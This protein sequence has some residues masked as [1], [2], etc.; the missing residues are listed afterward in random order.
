[1]DVGTSENCFEPLF[2]VEFKDDKGNSLSKVKTDIIVDR[3]ELKELAALRVGETSTI[4]FDAPAEACQMKIS[5]TFKAQAVIFINLSGTIGTMPIS[6]SLKIAPDGKVLGAYY[7][8]KYEQQYFNGQLSFLYL[9]G[10]QNGNHITMKEYTKDGRR[11]GSYSGELHED[12]TFTGTFT[13]NSGEHQFSLTT[14]SKARSIDFS[15]VDIDALAS[16]IV[17]DYDGCSSYETDSED[18]DKILDYYE[19]YVDKCISLAKRTQNGDIEALA[20][21]SSL[22]EEAQRLSDRL[23][24]AKDVMSSSQW[25][26]YYR[27]TSR[28]AEAASM[29]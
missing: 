13:A 18:W 19:R 21:Y 6:M 23:S 27:I 20:E 8:K 24:N 17:D 25:S 3:D 7:Y 28:M 11:N 29:P 15:D 12:G 2:T 5:S 26:R 4:K 10:E 9:T 22:L 16:M 1:M 14:D